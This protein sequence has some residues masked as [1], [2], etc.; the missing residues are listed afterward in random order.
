MILFD[1]KFT[2][3]GDMND[4]GVS[5]PPLKWYCKICRIVEDTVINAGGLAA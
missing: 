3:S 1:V 4:S 2:D 5:F